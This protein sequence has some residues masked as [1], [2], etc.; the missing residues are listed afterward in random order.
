VKG[1]SLIDVMH[2]FDYDTQKDHLTSAY[3]QLE[4]E[5][6]LIFREVDP[7]AGWISVLNR[8]YEKLATSVGFTRSNEEK[9]YFRKKEEWLGLLSQIGFRARAERCSSILFADVLFIG[10][11]S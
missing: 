6:V 7:E 3:E 11:K 2:Y 9:L 10:E 5:G 8:F 1:I 4:D